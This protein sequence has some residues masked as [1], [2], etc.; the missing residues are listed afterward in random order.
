MGNYLFVR[1]RTTRFNRLELLTSIF[2]FQKPQVINNKINKEKIEF[3]LRILSTENT[4]NNNE[5]YSY[6][7]TL[8]RRRCPDNLIISFAPSHFVKYDILLSY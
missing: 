7:Y 6:L 5:N 4:I 3:I 1:K 2:L 8:S